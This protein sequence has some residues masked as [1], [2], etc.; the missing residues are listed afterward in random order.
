MNV[1]LSCRKYSMLRTFTDMRAGE[2]MTIEQA[3]QWDQRPFRSMLYQHW[4]RYTPGKGFTVTREGREAA[5]SFLNTD[6]TR[7]D[8]T[9]P[10]TSYFDAEAYGLPR[11]R[12]AGKAAGSY[13]R[14]RQ[15]AAIAA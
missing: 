2:Y 6:I 8:P 14:R 13:R 9:R 11:R 10:L 15:E 5:A 12:Q 4:I 7:H 1:T 3:Q